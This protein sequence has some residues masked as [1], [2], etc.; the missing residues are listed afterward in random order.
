MTPLRVS[1]LRRIYLFLSYT[2]LH[3]H[4]RSA[5]ITPS[6]YSLQ[7]QSSRIPS[8]TQRNNN[9]RSNG[10]LGRTEPTTLFVV[11]SRRRRNGKVSTVLVGNQSKSGQDGNVRVD[12]RHFLF[13]HVVDL[14]SAQASHFLHLFFSGRGKRIR[15]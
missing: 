14:L 10:C 9:W 5:V 2:F 3:A 6:P 11:D 13:V 4:A 15:G 12:E 1:A 7:R 8:R